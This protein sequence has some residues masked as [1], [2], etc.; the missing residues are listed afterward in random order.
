MGRFGSHREAAWGPHAR[1]SSARR[2]DWG[3]AAVGWLFALVM[4]AAAAL[5]LSELAP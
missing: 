4:L 5:F 2:F 3:R 1:S